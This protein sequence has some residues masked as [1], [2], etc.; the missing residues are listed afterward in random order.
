NNTCIN[1]LT[2]FNLSGSFDSIVWDFG[3]PLSSNNSAVGI[4]NPIHQYSNVG[5][6]QVTATVTCQGTTQTIQ[7]EINVTNIPSVN[8]INDVFECET[9]VGSGISSNFDTSSIK[10]INNRCLIV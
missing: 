2:L 4:N 7:K 10:R 8:M 3:D 6:Y 5:S 1:E 9:V